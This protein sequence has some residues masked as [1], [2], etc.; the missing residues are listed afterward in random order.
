MTMPPEVRCVLANAD[1]PIAQLIK[2][3][4]A[5]ERALADAP[6]VAIGLSSNATI[7]ML[8][9]YLRREAA[10]VGVRARIVMGN[11]DDPIGDFERFAREG[12]ERVILV[13]IFDNVLPAFEAQVATL[14]SQ[15]L[16][17]KEAEL[18][19]RYSL[20][21]E[22]GRS[23]R[24]VQ[25]GLYHRLGV[26]AVPDSEDAVT[27]WIQRFN[28]MLREEAARHANVQLIDIAASVAAIGH[29]VAFDRRFYL[30]S[31][32]PYS[33]ALLSDLATRLAAGTRGFGTRFIKALALDCDNTLWGGVVGE[34]LVAGVKLDPHDYPG[35]VFWRTQQ[36]IAGLERQGLLLCLC[37]KN[38]PADVE[39]MFTHHPHMVLK[40]TQIAARRVNWTDKVTNLRE[41]AAELNIGL[42]S[43][44]FLDDSSVEAEAVRTRLPQVTMVQV[45]QTLSDYPAVID[46]I[47]RLFL[48][49]GIS[50]SGGSKTEQY[51]LRAAAAEAQ[52]AFATHEDYLASL[53]LEAALHLDRPTEA[54]RIAELSQK[55]NQFNLATRRYTQ[56]EIEQ[57]MAA[58]DAQVFSITVRNRFG[59]SGLTGV[60][61]LRYEDEVARVENFLMS[62]R[63]L[64][65]GIEF[66]LWTAVIERARAGGAV[67][68]E[69]DFIAS[70]KN[71]QVRDFYDRL[72]LELLD[73]NAGTRR[74]RRALTGF[75]PPS[76]SWVKVSDA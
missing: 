14:P 52:S 50:E 59:D 75:T 29:R 9:L 20:A 66:S 62:C 13:P 21:L 67:R 19:A 71:A 1:T 39:E 4:T 5:A 70:A 10:L 44:I 38:N 49:A 57:L 25:L 73:D 76:S 41:L 27:A 23:F 2:A 69:A 16:T 53:E 54:A 12:V 22:R 33:A 24:S 36:A 58:P 37:T 61:V 60:L 6:E 40:N 48:G 74:Y 65:Q 15:A 17:A 30:R 43:F 47:A 45:P 68:I 55:S 18:R 42:D 46:E 28:A 8:G 31:K 51:R 3:V 63:V 32:A 72:G 35:N 34:D 64:G 26:S 7:D 11:Y 56:L